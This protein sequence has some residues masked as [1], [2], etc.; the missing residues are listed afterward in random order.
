MYGFPYIVRYG[1]PCTRGTVFCTRHRSPPSPCFWAILTDMESADPAQSAGH[2]IMC[3]FMRR[4]GLCLGAGSI[5]N[6]RTPQARST[7]TLYSKQ[8]RTRTLYGRRAVSR[9]GPDQPGITATEFATRSGTLGRAFL[10]L[11]KSIYLR[12]RSGS[13]EISRGSQRQVQGVAVQ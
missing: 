13:S 7:R 1:L 10:Y 5:D 8:A 4:R 11:S 9:I 3:I 6:C 12:S 2:V